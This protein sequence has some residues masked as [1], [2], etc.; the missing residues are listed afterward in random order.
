MLRYK[1]PFPQSLLRKRQPQKLGHCRRRNPRSPMYKPRRSG[2]LQ[3]LQSHEKSRLYQH[4]RYPENLS[5]KGL[6]K[7]Q[8]RRPRPRFGNSFGVYS[9]LYD[10]AR[11]SAGSPRRNLSGFYARFVLEKLTKKSTI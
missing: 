3:V 9:L 2:R 6:Y 4:R 5:A 8:T 11:T 7:L 1:L 10:K